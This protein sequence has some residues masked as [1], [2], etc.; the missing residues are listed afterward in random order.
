[1]GK[2]VRFNPEQ[3]GKKGGQFRHPRR[4]RAEKGEVRSKALPP[5]S[6]DDV[7]FSAYEE[8]WH[9]RHPEVEAF[10]PSLKRNKSKW[11]NESKRVRKEA[12]SKWHEFD[13][14]ELGSLES[15]D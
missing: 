14:D 7:D 8:N 3:K 5:T 10:D 1:M 11:R 6:F 12:E 13:E 4:N 2:T 15:Y 9:S